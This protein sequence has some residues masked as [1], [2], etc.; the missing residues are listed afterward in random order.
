MAPTTQKENAQYRSWSHVTPVAFTGARFFPRRQA[1]HLL[2]PWSLHLWH[3]DVHML[4]RVSRLSHCGQPPTSFR[5]WRPPA[6][7][8]ICLRAVAQAVAGASEQ[9]LGPAE[10]RRPRVMDAIAPTPLEERIFVTLTEAA[11]WAQLGCTLRC[12][13]GWVRDKLL[14]QVGSPATDPSQCSRPSSGP[15]RERCCVTTSHSNAAGYADS[16]R[17]R[18]RK[19]ELCL[20]YCR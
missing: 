11:K 9:T 8:T 7:R 18:M 14:G 12:A 19:H 17:L 13:G 3:L 5:H 16:S 2:L 20:G 15:E 10:P 1:R 6:G 4:L